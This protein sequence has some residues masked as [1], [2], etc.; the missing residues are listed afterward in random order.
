M[1]E[2]YHNQPPSRQEAFNI[3]LETE[4]SAGEIHFQRLVTNQAESKVI[5]L[6][7]KLNEDDHDHAERIQI[8]MQDNGIEEY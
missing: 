7:Q 1:L 5:D 6:F 8:Y 4:R 3:A 2:K